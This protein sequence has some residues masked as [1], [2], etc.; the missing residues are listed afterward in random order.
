LVTNRLKRTIEDYKNK[1]TKI[2]ENKSKVTDH[3]N[4]ALKKLLERS[5]RLQNI[6]NDLKD[7]IQMTSY[8]VGGKYPDL[9]YQTALLVL[10]AILYFLN[11]FDLIPDIIPVLGFTDDAAVLAIVMKSVGSDLE[12][13]RDWKRRL[14][15]I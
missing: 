5:P 6:F 8:W 7:L 12:K 9:S 10:V 4:E 15:L 13:F 11:P 1:A 2:L 3:L 14:N